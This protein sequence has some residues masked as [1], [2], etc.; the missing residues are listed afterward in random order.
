MSSERPGPVIG[1]CIGN[2]RIVEADI[3]DRE[4][5]DLVRPAHVTFEA[6]GHGE[7]AFGC[8]DVGL[9]CEHSER[10]VFFTFA[11]FD[12]MDEI[13]GAGSAEIGD[14]GTLDIEIRF[15]LGDD[16]ELKARRA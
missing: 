1:A 9:D 4:Y 2:W 6:G 3:W 5:L 16:A 14:D 15:H 7:M 13:S 12:E 8:V 10:T 11:G